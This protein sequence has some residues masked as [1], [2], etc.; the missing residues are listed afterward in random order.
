MNAG[1]FLEAAVHSV[2]EQQYSNWAL[3]LVNDGSS[4]ESG[5]L[6]AEF[7]R[8]HAGKILYLR[9]TGGVNRGISASRNLGCDATE[10]E[11]VTF[12]DADDVMLPDRLAVQVS[13]L[14]QHNDAAVLVQPKLR[15]HSW[16]HT[17]NGSLGNIPDQVQ[18]L[19][20]P[21]D[22]LVEPPNVLAAFLEDPLAT[23]IGILVR[24]QCLESVGGFEED[25]AGMYEDQVMQAKLFLR[26]KTYVAPEVTYKYRQHN[27]SVVAQSSRGGTLWTSRIRYLNWLLRY[28]LAHQPEMAQFRKCIEAQKRL[29][30]GLDRKQRKRRSRSKLAERLKGNRR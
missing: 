16:Q 24:R 30:E 12:L 17:A 27:E 3:A 5:R 1:E 7:S 9:H 29:A 26:Y 19:K 10:S 2:L 21:L 14:E 13:R 4:D 20:L 25:F 18:D 11:F 6:A 28:Q 8:Q 15:W 23:P 22:T